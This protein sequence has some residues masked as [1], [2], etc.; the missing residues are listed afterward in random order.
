MCQLLVKFYEILNSESQ[1]FGPLT[2]QDLP[3]LGQS[4]VGLYSALATDTKEAGVKMWKMMPT[5]HLFQH[6]CEWQAVTH[7]N[8]RYYW[9]YADEDLAG[10][11][12]EVATSCHPRTMATSALFK[13]LHLSFHE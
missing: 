11:M 1:F 10:L 3:K 5:L 6:L 12:A 4:L 13:W 9:C 8:P 2:K 7:G